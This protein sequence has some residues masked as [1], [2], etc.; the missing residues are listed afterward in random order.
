MRFETQEAGEEVRLL[1]RAHPIVLLPSLSLFLGLSILPLVTP[2]LLGLLQVDLA[3]VFAPRQVFFMVIFWYL[4][5]VGY[6][7]YKLVFYYF[8]AY[9]VTNERIVDFDFRGILNKQ[10]AY[11]KLGQIEDVTPKVVGFFG[12]FFHYGNVFIQ[13]AAERPEFEFENVPNPDYVA[14]VIMQE[15]RKEEM[16]KPGEVS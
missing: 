8:N 4:V 12:T 13:T 7:F 2:A 5:L 9:L 3:Q 15:M 11:T 1:L 14:E 16:E 10:T 6:L